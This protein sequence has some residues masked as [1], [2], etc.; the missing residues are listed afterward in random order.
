MRRNQQRTY[1]Y[2]LG[3]CVDLT[4]ALIQ[5]WFKIPATAVIPPPQNSTAHSQL[6][7]APFVM[8]LGKRTLRSDLWERVSA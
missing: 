8:D 4:N 1:A 3:F 5:S 6:Q 2:L 7:A